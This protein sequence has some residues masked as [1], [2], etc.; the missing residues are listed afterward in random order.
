MKVHKSDVK[1][2]KVGK[3]PNHDGLSRNPTPKGGERP[4]I[5]PHDNDP[6]LVHSG[7]AGGK[8][9]LPEDVV[10]PDNFDKIHN[11]WDGTSID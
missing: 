10:L 9:W 5:I 11:G 3:Q 7:N 1:V 4:S 2:Q 8:G 6:K